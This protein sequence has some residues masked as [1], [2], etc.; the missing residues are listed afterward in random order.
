VK[1]LSHTSGPRP[2]RA[3]AFVY[4]TPSKVAAHIY[5]PQSMGREPHRIVAFTLKELFAKMVVAGLEC[6]NYLRHPFTS[7]M[8]ARQIF[9]RNVSKN[10]RLLGWS[11][12]KLQGNE[13]SEVA[14]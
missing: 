11:P 13:K 14:A 2:Q 12:V 4:A 3:V 6:T 9:W 7:P 5:F 10:T 1:P 8:W